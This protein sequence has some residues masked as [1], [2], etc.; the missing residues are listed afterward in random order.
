MEINPFLFQ[1][2]SFYTN[3]NNSLGKFDHNFTASSILGERS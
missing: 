1:V 3:I 2:S